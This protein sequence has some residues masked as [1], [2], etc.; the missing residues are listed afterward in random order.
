MFQ[1]SVTFEHTRNADHIFKS[2]QDVLYTLCNLST[3]ENRR[4]LSNC[5]VNYHVCWDTLYGA[6][7]RYIHQEPSQL[8]LQNNCT[9]VTGRNI[10]KHRQTFTCGFFIK[11]NCAFLRIEIILTLFHLKNDKIFQIINQIKVSRVPL[12]ICHYNL[13]HGRHQK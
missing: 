7:S 3:I 9:A 5:L 12:R 4:R 1:I 6:V 8:G 10:N 11:I 13:M 2:S